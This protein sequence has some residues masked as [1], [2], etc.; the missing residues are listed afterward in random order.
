[1]D[2]QLLDLEPEKLSELVPEKVRK[3]F[4]GNIYTFCALDGEE[5]IGIAVFEATSKKNI[6][7]ALKYIFVHPEYRLSGIASQLVTEGCDALMSA[8]AK[9]VKATC[10]GSKEELSFAKPLFLSLGFISTISDGQVL[11]YR[12]SEL[13]K[14]VLSTRL[15]KMKP[16]MDKVEYISKIQKKTLR[17]FGNEMAS[18]NQPFNPEGF[19]KFF[20]RFYV[21]NNEI[22]GYMNL[23]EVAEN[24]VVLKDVFLDNSSPESKFYLPAML[25]SMLKVSFPVM[26]DETIFHLYIY[27]ENHL[28]GIKTVFGDTMAEEFI[29]EYL[30]K[31]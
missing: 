9:Y 18:K 20:A 10:I 27:N 25:A 1:M 28:T 5:I 14:C 11:T 16:L 31:F 13:K 19:D 8:G 15:D 6:N 22:K 2:I 21:D 26:P 23:C 4:S 12:L 7:V 17:T 29:E 30:M 3:E 24:I